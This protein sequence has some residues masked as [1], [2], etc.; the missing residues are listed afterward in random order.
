MN[1]PA[2]AC[3]VTGST[4]ENISPLLLIRTL[5]DVTRRTAH[6]AFFPLS[7]SSETQVY[8]LVVGNAASLYSLNA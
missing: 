7:R 8:K 5:F 3:A 6:T 1:C 2:C 4:P